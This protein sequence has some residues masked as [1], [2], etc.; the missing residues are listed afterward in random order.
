MSTAITRDP[1]IQGGAPVFTGTR[2]T[3]DVMLDYLEDGQSLDRFLE[4]YPQ[5]PRAQAVGALEEIKSMLAVS[6]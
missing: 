4:L 1:E 5:I 6:A 3:V 2:V